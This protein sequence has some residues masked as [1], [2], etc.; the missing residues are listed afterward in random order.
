MSTFTFSKVANNDL[1]YL[2]TQYLSDLL[3]SHGFVCYRNN[4]RRWHKVNSETILSV[5]FVSDQSFAMFYFGF[6]PMYYPFRFVDGPMKLHDRI[7]SFFDVNNLYYQMLSDAEQSRYMQ[8]YFFSSETMQQQAEFYRVI[9]ETVVF[10]ILDRV[11]DER[12]CHEAYRMMR[13][14][15]KQESWDARWLLECIFANDDKECHRIV[16]E[17]LPGLADTIPLSDDNWKPVVQ[18]DTIIQEL[19]AGENARYRNLMTQSI[20]ENIQRLK[21]AGYI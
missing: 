4:G 16:E 14:M 1:E 15:R 19:K 6:Q 3:K 10:P 18:K 13:N 9:L 12:S 17:I 8:H 7:W 20:T 11:T 5:Q 2:V 21:R